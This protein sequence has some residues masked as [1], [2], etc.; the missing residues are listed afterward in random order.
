[1]AAA[2]NPAIPVMDT[3]K[4]SSRLHSM[5]FCLCLIGC[6]DFGVPAS[7]AYCR[8]SGK[9]RSVCFSPACRLWRKRIDTT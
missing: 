7:G 6:G 5:K 4:Q 1:V 2:A 3:F 9:V 8:E